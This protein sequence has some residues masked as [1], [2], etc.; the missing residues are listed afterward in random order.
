MKLRKILLCMFISILVFSITNESAFA[1]TTTKTTQEKATKT[2]KVANTTKAA[3]QTT[4]STAAKKTVKYTE[5][6]LRLM[7]AIIYCEASSESY[8]G[9]LAVGIVIMNR[10]RSNRYPNSV[11]SVIYQKSQFSP[12]KSGSLNKALA[13]YD[14]GGFTSAK[15]KDSINAAKAALDGQKYITVNGKKKDFS[16]YHSFSNKIKGYTFKLGHHQF[17]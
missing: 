16:K 1:A 4:K 2:T 8:N 10:V 14:K 13:V 6:D 17:K 11:K 15:E 3:S 7:S 9:K 5:A 12:V